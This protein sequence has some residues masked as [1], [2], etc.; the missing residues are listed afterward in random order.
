MKRQ[1]ESI[2]G[3]MMDKIQ[4][5]RLSD[6]MVFN[7]AMVT[8]VRFS[9]YSGD[10]GASYATI[11]VSGTFPITVTDGELGALKRW[12]VNH[13]DASYTKSVS[14]KNLGTI[15]GL[16]NYL[17]IG[18]LHDIESDLKDAHYVSSGDL[19]AIEDIDMLLRHVRS[20]CQLRHKNEEVRQIDLDREG[21]SNGD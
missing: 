4:L 15:G 2:K 17:D 19:D 18:T 20:V 10:D 11:H 3:K 5:V 9:H 13:I 14:D 21:G 1:M 6:E 8:S 16:L 12:I 7:P